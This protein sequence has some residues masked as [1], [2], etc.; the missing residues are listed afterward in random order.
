MRLEAMVLIAA[1][2]LALAGGMAAADSLPDSVTV[3]EQAV[4]SETLSDAVG[5]SPSTSATAPD[6]VAVS[7]GNDPVTFDQP[8]SASAGI[9]ITTGA[10]AITNLEGNFGGAAIRME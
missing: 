7:L 9:S 10:A 8:S 6:G 2:C 1:L 4:D 3:D 5:N